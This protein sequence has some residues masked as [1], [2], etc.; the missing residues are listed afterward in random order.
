MKKTVIAKTIYGT[1]KYLSKRLHDDVL[2]IS[3]NR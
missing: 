1:M 3:K 2:H